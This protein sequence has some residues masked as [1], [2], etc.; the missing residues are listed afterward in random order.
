[1]ASTFIE[2]TD[3]SDL[4]RVQDDSDQ[5]LLMAGRLSDVVMTTWWPA[6]EG[7]R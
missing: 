2:L 5:Q 6:D 3:S 7:R 4:G 1:M